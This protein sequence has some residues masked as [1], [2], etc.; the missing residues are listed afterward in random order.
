MLLCLPD[1]DNDGDGAH[2]EDCD[3]NGNRAF[4]T[5]APISGSHGHISAVGHEFVLMFLE[6]VGSDL[7]GRP[8]PPNEIFVTAADSSSLIVKVE[9]PGK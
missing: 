3:S 2:D 4:S 5:A 1:T 7:Q 6:N 9:A 8:A